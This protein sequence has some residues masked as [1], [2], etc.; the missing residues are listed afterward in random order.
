MNTR[1]QVEHPVT[2]LVTGLDLVALQLAVAQGERAAVRAADVR[3][4]G[5]AIE[6]RVY[7]EDPAHGFLPQAGRGDPGALARASARR[8]GAGVRPAGQHPLRPDA[9]Q[10]DRR[11]ARPAR[12]PGGRWCKRSTTRPWSA[13]PRT[14]ASCERSPTHR[15]SRAPTS[16]PAGSTPIR[17]PP[18]L[19]V[20]EAAWLLAAWS[21]ATHDVGDP[22]DPF[23]QGDGWRLAGPAAPVPV[24][25]S[26]TGGPPS[27]RVL[28]VAVAGGV[29]RTVTPRSSSRDGGQVLGR[30]RLEID[31]E[32]LAGHVL[33][34]P[35][36]VLVAYQGQTCSF[37][38][39]DAFGASAQT[40]RRRRY[41]AGADARHGAARR[42]CRG[43]SRGGRRL[44]GRA[45]RR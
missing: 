43:A 6:A 33:I 25:L 31:G 12:P 45:W 44:A 10:G 41:R 36:R 4:V 22:A 8:P 19:I 20:P 2:E 1:L 40:A 26:L 24:E 15:S 30:Q 5:H 37:D 21:L 13:S 17:R 34:E 27:A 28:S 23:V 9:R 29:I 18:S 32:L 42:R 35:H 14:S 11:A 16:T 3:V 38:R 7:A 39:P